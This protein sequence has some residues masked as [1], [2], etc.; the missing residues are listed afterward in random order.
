MT[1]KCPQ[2]GRF[3]EE[4]DEHHGECSKCGMYYCFEQGCHCCDT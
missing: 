3:L 1:L 2:C 4:E